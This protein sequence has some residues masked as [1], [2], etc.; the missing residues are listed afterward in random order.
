MPMDTHMLN[1]SVQSKGGGVN[2]DENSKLQYQQHS[3]QTTD[4]R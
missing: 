3:R 1:I 4:Y 2:T